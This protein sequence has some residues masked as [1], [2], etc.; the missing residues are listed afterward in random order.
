[1]RLNATEGHDRVQPV[2]V[3]SMDTVLNAQAAPRLTVALFGGSRFLFWIMTDFVQAVSTT[4]NLRWALIGHIPDDVYC[5]LQCRPITTFIQPSHYLIDPPR[6]L[7][8]L[9]FSKLETRG[10]P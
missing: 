2:T 1:M 7:L 9:F 5:R 10:Q 3:M 4:M 6:V 8:Q